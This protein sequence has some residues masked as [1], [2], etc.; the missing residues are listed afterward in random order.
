MDETE[1]KPVEKPSEDQTL[2]DRVMKVMKEVRDSDLAM[3][4]KKLESFEAKLDEK[5]DGILKAK[6]VEVEQALRK[7]FGLEQDP[8]VHMSD[9]ISAIRKASLEHAETEKRT[10]GPEN[11]PG[12]EGTVTPSALDKLLEEFGVKEGPK[13]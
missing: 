2:F 7:G 4:Q 13:Q 3:F 6:E 11:K 5:I 10:P 12:P 8:V 9:M 1:A